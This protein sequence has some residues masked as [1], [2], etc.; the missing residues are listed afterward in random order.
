MQ[1]KFTFLLNKI[2]DIHHPI[3]QNKIQAT[4]ELILNSFKNQKVMS[5][6]IVNVISKGMEYLHGFQQ[7]IDIY[8]SFS[9]MFNENDESIHFFNSVR[10]S[11]SV[12][13]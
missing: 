7:V 9:T 4:E 2:D 13:K 11:I 3:F 8:E 6:T 10:K 12:Q 5:Q 1:T